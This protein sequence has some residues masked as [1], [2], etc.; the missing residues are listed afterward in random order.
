MARITIGDRYEL[1]RVQRDIENAA[2]DASPSG[3]AYHRAQ[4]AAERARERR[5][6]IRSAIERDPEVQEVRHLV[7]LARMAGDVDTFRDLLGV[8]RDALAGA[9]KRHGAAL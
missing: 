3:R 4:L 1:S 8:Y 5:S 6:E 2:L 9:V 7:A